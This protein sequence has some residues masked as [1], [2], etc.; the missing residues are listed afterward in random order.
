MVVPALLATI[1]GFRPVAGAADLKSAIDALIESEVESGTMVGIQVST[2]QGQE[3]YSHMADIRFVPA[4]NQKLLSSILAF[5]MLGPDHRF[6]TRFWRDGDDVWVDAPGDQTITS[7]Q[8]FEIKARLEVSGRGVVRVKQAYRFDFG[9]SWEDDDKPFRYAPACT[10]FSVDRAQFDISIRG[11]IPT[12]PDWA[13]VR[14]RHI[15]GLSPAIAEFDRVHS[16]VTIRGQIDQKP[17]VLATFALR[18]PDLSAARIL[19]MQFLPTN[20]LP[21][22]EPDAEIVG[23]PL[24]DYA[25]LCLEPSDNLLAESLLFSGTGK[26]TWPEA[27]K[28]MAEHHTMTSGL[29]PGALRPEDGSGMSRHNLATPRALAQLLRHA[30]AQPYR[31]DFMRA[32]AHSGEGTM[33]ARL[34]GLDVTAKTGTLDSV[35]CLSGYL[36]I[37]GGRTVVFSIMMNHYTSSAA[38]ARKLQDSIVQA[39][40]DALSLDGTEHAIRTANWCDPMG[41]GLPLSSPHLVDGY[42]LH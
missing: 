30:I 31:D 5:D 39:I 27:A 4:S 36:G 7:A 18:D 29:K 3:I 17:G 24:R 2:P 38:D 12:V 16:E 42:R 11:G 19:G 41:Q 15:D 35:S 37:P 23:M 28:A 34:V 13:G 1:I 21:D 10:A 8:L 40:H 14:V 25:K 33:R 22:R 6:H 20:V 32:M 26:D 9:P